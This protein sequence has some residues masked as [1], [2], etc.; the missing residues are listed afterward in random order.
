M[1]PAI[2]G[3]AGPVLTSDEC[4]FFKAADPA[5]YVLFRRNVADPAQLRALTDALRDL[6]GRD[7]LAIM[8]DQE[9]GRVTRLAP[10]A[11]PAFPAQGCFAALYEKAPISAIE[12]ARVNAQALAVT[13][14]EVGINVDLLPVLDLRIEGQHDIVGDRALGA[15]PMQVAALGRAV[16]DGLEAGG[17]IGVVKHMPGHGRARAD[18]HKELPVVGA[19]A[20]EL[21]TDI[22]PFRSLAGAPMA[23]TA[24]VLYPAW[25]AERAATV[26]PTVIAQVIR[27]EIGFDGLLMS[28]DLAM[29]ALFGSYAERA[30]AT[31]AAGCDL[32]LFCTGVL[33]DNE[34][35]AGAL[36][37]IG[38]AAAGRLERAM[39]R[40]GK[41]SA[42]SYE[43]LA[44]KRDALLALI[45]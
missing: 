29:E 17:A 13:L 7:D 35:V 20:A 10:P 38:D 44:A 24:H 25:D 34:A 9:G 30:T 14:A 3:F 40:T 6:S 43:E 32:A 23:M 12:A 19:S 39:A 8:V 4:A 18:S 31:L 21:E 26:S 36:P 42:Q 27:G 16:L 15:E 41:R 2:L 1:L 45:P 33:A 28:D 5:G 11:F 22:A 37:P